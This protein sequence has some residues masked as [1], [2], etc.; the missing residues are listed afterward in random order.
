MCVALGGVCIT[1][2]LF[3]EKLEPFVLRIIVGVGDLFTGRV[4]WNLIPV[5]TPHL[6]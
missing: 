4:L 3:I 2:N 5:K 6:L 1:K